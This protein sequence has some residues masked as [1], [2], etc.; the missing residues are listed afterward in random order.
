MH[1]PIDKIA[2]DVEGGYNVVVETPRGSRVKFAYDSE[3]GLLRAKKLLVTG[4]AFPFPF[5]FLP[6]TKAQHGEPLDVLPERMLTCRR[7]RW[8]CTGCRAGLRWRRLEREILR[9]MTV[10]WPSRGC[11]IR[12]VHPMSSRT[13]PRPNSRESSSWSPTIADGKEAKV[14]GRTNKAE[15][16]SIVRKAAQP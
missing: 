6:S 7:A 2:L 11:C 15:A 3:A 10:C 16:E 13:S 8:C 9:E 12:I 1:A 5:G 14:V 4:F